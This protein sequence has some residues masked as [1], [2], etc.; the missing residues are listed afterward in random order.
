M[1]LFSRHAEREYFLGNFEKV[2]LHLQ[3]IFDLQGKKDLEDSAV[4]ADKL[5]AAKAWA[6]LGITCQALGESS[7]VVTDAYRHA[8]DLFDRW[9]QKINFDRNDDIYYGM[10]LFFLNRKD[11]AIIYLNKSI[12]KDTKE[13]GLLL[14]RPNL[15]GKK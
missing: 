1:G 14:F 4:D 13:S 7:T 12:D 15:L 9:S 3:R 5:A 11:E 2:K 8:V 10:S 6:L